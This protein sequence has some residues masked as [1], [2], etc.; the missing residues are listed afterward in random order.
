MKITQEYHNQVPVF[1]GDEIQLE[2]L[3]RIGVPDK[4]IPNPGEITE[5]RFQRRHDPSGIFWQTESGIIH[6]P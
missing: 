6:K 5:F 2:T 4:K 3:K 1:M